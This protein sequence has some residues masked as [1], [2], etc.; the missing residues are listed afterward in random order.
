MQSEDYT[1][2]PPLLWPSVPVSAN[3]SYR[4]GFMK[5]FLK[6]DTEIWEKTRLNLFSFLS[7]G[8]QIH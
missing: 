2:Y 6:K 4:E 3:V 7:S 8:T 1:S 5:K